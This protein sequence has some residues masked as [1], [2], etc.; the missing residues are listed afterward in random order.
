MMTAERNSSNQKDFYFK[1]FE[2]LALLETA[3]GFL[4]EK[5]DTNLQIS[6]IG[7]VS[8]F[9]LDKNIEVSKNMEPLILYWK[10]TLDNTTDFGSLYNPEIG[11][12]FIVGTLTSIFL[13]KVDGKTLGMLSVGAHGILRGIG[14]TEKQATDYI[15]LLKNGNYLLIYKGCKEEFKNYKEVLDDKVNL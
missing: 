7:K 5:G 14:A 6:I 15:K 11:N 3:L 12:V 10:D 4:K 9:Y 8:Q 13:E 2:N 1:A